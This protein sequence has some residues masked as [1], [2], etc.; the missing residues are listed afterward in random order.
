[1]STF[2]ELLRSCSRADASCLFRLASFF[3]TGKNALAMNKGMFMK[4]VAKGNR[5]CCAEWH[6]HMLSKAGKKHHAHQQTSKRVNKAKTEWHAAQAKHPAD[7]NKAHGTTSAQQ[8]LIGKGKTCGG[9][10][11]SK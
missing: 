9:Y 8:Q 7:A 2:A 11:G 6:W 10:A 4:G 1:M 3:E 5:F